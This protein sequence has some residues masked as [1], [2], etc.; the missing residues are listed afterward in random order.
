MKRG[1][2]LIALLTLAGCGGSSTMVETRT[3]PEDSGPV[4]LADHETFD[5]TR[6]P[7]EPVAPA[8]GAV[9]IEHDV[10]AE[11]MENRADAGVERTVSG[12]RVQVLAT[13]DPLEAEQME[14]RVRNWWE[15]RASTLPPNSPLPQD[16]SIHRTFRQ[17]YYRIRLGNFIT[18]ASADQLLEVVSAAFEDAFVVP[19]R[20]T[21]R[22]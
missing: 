6:F 22:R 20:V 17:P 8:T 10:P 5:V 15:R 2:L 13:L 3:E 18:R 14:A 11:L 7:D 16:L 1:F 4:I 21:V 19:D 9:R 12:F